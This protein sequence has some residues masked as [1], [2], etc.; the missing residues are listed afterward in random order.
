VVVV[1]DVCS[2]QLIQSCRHHASIGLKS[3][4]SPLI[5]NKLFCPVPAQVPRSGRSGLGP[6]DRRA[7]GASRVRPREAGPQPRARPRRLGAADA[8]VPGRQHP[9]VPALGADR[10]RRHV[11]LQPRQGAG[12]PAGGRHPHHRL[13]QRHAQPAQD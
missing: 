7:P 6:A 10:P 2:K 13:R 1:D 5:L 4:V 11:P 12:A 8:H 3:K 9:R